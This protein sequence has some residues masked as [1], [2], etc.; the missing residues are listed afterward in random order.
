M[1]ECVNLY[2]KWEHFHLNKY[3]FILICVY[4]TLHT[5]NYSYS[6]ELK[7]EN[8]KFFVCCSLLL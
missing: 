6:H 8:L 4:N 1:L 3:L 2:W 5:K 7:K